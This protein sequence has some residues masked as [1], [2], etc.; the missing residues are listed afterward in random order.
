MNAE[1]DQTA[2]WQSGHPVY[3]GAVGPWAHSELF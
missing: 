2:I 1:V 3:E